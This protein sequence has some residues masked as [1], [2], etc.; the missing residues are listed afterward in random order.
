VCLYPV[1]KEPRLHRS[2]SVVLPLSNAGNALAQN[3]LQLCE[4]LSDLTEWFEV[5][6]VDEGASEQAADAAYELA[7]EYPQVRVLRGQVPVPRWTLADRAGLPS[8]GDVVLIHRPESPLRPS[9]VRRIWESRG[10]Y[11]RSHPRAVRDGGATGA[12]RPTGLGSTATGVSQSTSTCPARE[13]E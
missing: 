11:P 4:V 9:E 2:L 8:Q 13:L 7:A 3:V 10:E 12:E 1:R 6:L 5:L